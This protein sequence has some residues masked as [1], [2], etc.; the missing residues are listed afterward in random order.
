MAPRLHFFVSESN[1]LP[2]DCEKGGG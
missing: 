2:K 1:E